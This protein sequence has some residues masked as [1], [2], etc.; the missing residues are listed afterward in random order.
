MIYITC[1]TFN[2]LL[3]VCLL[4]FIVDFISVPVVSAFTSATSLIIIASQL[5]NL[6]GFDFESKS[7][8]DNFSGMY[9]NIDKTTYWDTMLSLVCC[10]FLLA[11]RVSINNNNAIN[12]ILTN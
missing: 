2:I 3:S 8:W 11:L 7:F 9:E 1:I 12:K 4:G 10:I 6:A 5:K